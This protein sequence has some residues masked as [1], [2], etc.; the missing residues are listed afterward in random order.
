[1]TQRP[2]GAE[3]RPISVAELL[4]RSGTIGAPPPAARRH[5]RRGNNDAVKVTDLTGDIPVIGAEH[6]THEFASGS[7]ADDV[8]RA[9]GLDGALLDEALDESPRGS[10]S[11]SHSPDESPKPSQSPEAPEPGPYPWL[12]S[13]PDRV[14]SQAEPK[15]DT[16]AAGSTTAQSDAEGMSPDP[17]EDYADMPVDVMDSD[18]RNAEPATDDSAYVRSYLHAPDP[19]PTR[20][21]AIV[22]DGESGSDEDY[23]DTG[24]NEIGGLEDVGET[25]PGYVVGDEEAE[26]PLSRA[27]TMLGGGLVV[28][29]SVL[30]VGFGAG[31]FIAFEQLWQWNNIMALLLSVLVILGLVAGV[32]VVRK[33]EDIGS[34]LTAVA[35]GALVTLGPLVL[36]QSG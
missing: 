3:T 11:E 4:A 20:Q 5:R 9:D 23:P 21:T 25:Q 14:D 36:L 13:Q 30:A 28:L 17:L 27:G 7:E 10:E 26:P 2:D 22:G 8:D 16:Q 31:L 35:V 32:R 34:T 24:D 12:L 6:G 18:V 15:A 1:M 33:T 29:Q 19:A